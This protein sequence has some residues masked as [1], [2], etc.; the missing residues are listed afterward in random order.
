MGIQYINSKEII[1]YQNCV[2]NYYIRFYLKARFIGG[3]I[4]KYFVI[5]GTSKKPSSLDKNTFDTVLQNHLDYL[6]KWFD[7]GSILLAAPKANND[8]GFIIMKAVSLEEVEKFVSMDPLKKADVQEYRIVEFKLHD[9]QP[10]L[11]EWFNN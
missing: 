3:F 7:S 10:V 5:E 11:K 1:I 2:K 4:M 9:C 6:Q 8:G